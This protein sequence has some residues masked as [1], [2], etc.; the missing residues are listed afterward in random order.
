LPG[1]RPFT[2]EEYVS[3]KTPSHPASSP[4]GPVCA[5]VVTEADFEESR[6]VSH[7]WLVDSGGEE[8]RQITFSHEGEDSP[9]F[10]PDGSWLA[11]LSAR[12]DYSRPE[13]ELDEDEE[14]KVQLWIL[15]AAGG[16]AR[17]LTDARE[18]VRDYDW[19]PDS[20]GLIYLAPEARPKA[21]Q[22]HRFNRLNE[23]NDAV[24]EHEEKH[25][26]G[27]WRVETEEDGENKRVWA[28]D[29]GGM[30]VA[31]S[32]DGKQAVYVTN[33]SGEPNDYARTDLWLLNLETGE[34]RPLV[35]RPGPEWSPQWSPDG[36]KVA[37]LAGLD[38]E[39]SYSQTQLW[40]VEVETGEIRRLLPDFDHEI[41]QF[42]W[43]RNAPDTILFTAPLGLEIALL[44]LTVSTGAVERWTQSGVCDG[45]D[46]SEDGSI[47]YACRESGTAWPDL[48]R[49]L[50]E[51]EQEKPPEEGQ[52]A[53][54]G[55]LRLTDLNPEWREVALG[56]QRVLRWTSDGGEI[57]GLLVLPPNAKEGDRYPL[58]V[59]VHGGPHGATY[60]TQRQGISLQW[61]AQRGYA[62]LSPNY[63][64]SSNG[65]AAFAVANRRDLGGGDYRDVMAGVDAALAEGIADPDRLAIMGGSYGGYMTNWAISQTD[66]FRAAI[67]L[68]GVFNWITDFSNSEISHFEKEYFGDYYW[69]DPTLYFERSPFRYVERIQTPVLIFHGDSDPNTFIS[70]SREMYQALRALGRTVSFVRYPREGHG[71]HE[72][73]H[74]V[75]LLNRVLVWLDQYL[76][77]EGENPAVYR[78]D[79]LVPGENQWSL[80]V[81]S[82]E[83]VTP[84]GYKAPAENNAKNGSSQYSL[85]NLVFVLLSEA[86]DAA[87]SLEFDSLRLEAL[88]EP[89]PFLGVPVKTL[90]EVSLVQGAGLK[91][92]F[93]GEEPPS[94]FPVAAVFQVP[95]AAAELQLTVPGFPSVLLPLPKAEKKEEEEPAHEG[96]DVALPKEDLPAPG[97]VQKRGCPD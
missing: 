74:R 92:T 73:R 52:E 90:D 54:E 53:E 1:Q 35:Q 72:P 43:P 60:N 15:P 89:C 9:A 19:L 83:S 27:V 21:I 77:G 65:T 84:A 18:G 46:A 6:V 3:L 58:V 57:E 76:S 61:L 75:D 16:E 14:P 20:S 95:K 13:P 22:A 71:F 12:P 25:R 69:E 66:R 68:F 31:V 24:V 81:T 91:I 88:G 63:R 56:P 10:S 62:V 29:F 11:F 39:V 87:F 40:S 50:S 80:R 8:F 32:P 5:F 38:P 55:Y 44:R 34:A 78:L 23:K 85:I 79:Q 67:S 49:R 37:F 48:Y 4:E 30:S 47:V 64:G 59:Y 42:L 94:A 26:G 7:L 41:E 33:Y 45:F 97:P 86:K 2:A 17:C 36:S 51:E 96:P 82:V 70:N 28:G 93:H